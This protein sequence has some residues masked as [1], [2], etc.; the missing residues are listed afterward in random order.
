[1]IRR[2]AEKYLAFKNCKI[3]NIKHE[4]IHKDHL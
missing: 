3:I 2:D 1:M 4:T